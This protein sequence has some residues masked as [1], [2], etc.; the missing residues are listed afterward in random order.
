MLVND[1]TQSQVDCLNKLGEKLGAITGYKADSIT[2]REAYFL[3][4]KMSRTLSSGR[5]LGKKLVNGHWR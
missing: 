1:A 2:R 5:M 3:I 4:G